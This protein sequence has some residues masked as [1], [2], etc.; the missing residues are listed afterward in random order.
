[1]STPIQLSESLNRSWK[2]EE[3]TRQRMEPVPGD[4]EYLVL[5]DLRIF[6]DQFRT[7]NC[8]SVLDFGAGGSPYRALFRKSNYHRADFVV[9][10][11]LDFIVDAHSRIAALSE[12][13]DIILSTQ[14]A[15]H[16]EYPY[17]YLDECYRLLKPGGTLILTTH[18]T[19]EDHGVPYD[20]QRWTAAGLKRDV[21][22]VGFCDVSAFKLTTSSRA[23]FCLFLKWI[24]N[25]DFGFSLLGKCLN[26]F[27]CMVCNWLIK[28]CHMAAD[29]FWPNARVVGST[30]PNSNFYL[31]VAC[32]AK[33]PTGNS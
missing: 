10:E 11:G 7:D 2:S 9:T 27:R 23:Y 20:F 12:S 25:F 26:R 15:E 24:C 17:E 8:S 19:W 31:V 21:A 3:F 32:T 14:V 1:M 13:Y 4:P 18:G 28:P 29:Y 6:L 16:V 5:S 22:G 33:K 30:E